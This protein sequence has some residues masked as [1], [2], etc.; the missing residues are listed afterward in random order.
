MSVFMGI[1]DTID[2]ASTI[3]NRISMTPWASVSEILLVVGLVWSFI[4]LWLSAKKT[5]KKAKI[6][7]IME[8]PTSH[9]QVEIVNQPKKPMHHLFDE[10]EE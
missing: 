1:V 10:L 9:K 4:S 5:S 7:N 8:E 3:S 2:M 6:L